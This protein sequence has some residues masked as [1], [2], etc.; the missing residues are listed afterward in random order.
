MESGRA[1]HAL[2][3]RLAE[4][5]GRVA[6]GGGWPALGGAVAVAG[7]LQ[8]A[9][10]ELTRAAA[11]LRALLAERVVAAGGDPGAAARAAD[12]VCR[13]RGV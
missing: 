12:A 11:E 8:D 9:E 7:E 3:A 5:L 2:R 6:E 4:E 1:G 13:V 10:E